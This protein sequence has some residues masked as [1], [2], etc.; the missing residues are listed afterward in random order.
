MPAFKGVKPGDKVFLE[1]YDGENIIKK[2]FILAAI[3]DAPRSLGGYAFSMPDKA[4]R[5]FSERDLT[6]KYF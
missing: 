1:L 6:Y 5:G 4:L 3:V 2:E